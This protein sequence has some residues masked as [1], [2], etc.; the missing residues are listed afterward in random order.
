MQIYLWSTTVPNFTLLVNTKLTL[1]PD[2]KPQTKS[3]GI[4]YSSSNLGTRK[5]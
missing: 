5:G 2:I 1:Q 3:E 4:V